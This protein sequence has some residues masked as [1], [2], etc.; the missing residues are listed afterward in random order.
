V[1][2][3][4]VTLVAETR[5]L[6][7]IS[8]VNSVAL[9]TNTS[10]CIN[11]ACLLS[12]DIF[13]TRL[14]QFIFSNMLRC[15]IHEVLHIKNLVKGQGQV[16]PSKYTV[17]ANDN[18]TSLRISSACSSHITTISFISQL[19]LKLHGRP[20]NIV[21]LRRTSYVNTVDNNNNNNNYYY[22]YYYKLTIKA[23]NER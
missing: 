15:C 17:V 3:N 23:Y 5:E 20:Y 10:V 12:I 22:Y 14:S 2:D 9:A 21:Y 11:T 18:F 19:I 7:V 4:I 6:H 1:E 13:S 8:V 16:I